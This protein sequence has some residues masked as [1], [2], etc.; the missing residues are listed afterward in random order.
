MQNSAPDFAVNDSCAGERLSVSLE[1]WILTLGN[2]T[3]TRASATGLSQSPNA[4]LASA[5]AAS[6][7][8]AAPALEE[9]GAP[10]REYVKMLPIRPGATPLKFAPDYESWLIE[11]MRHGENDSF[12]TEMGSSVVDH[13]AEHPSPI[14]IPIVPANAANQ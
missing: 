2:A 14:L 11:A 9:L 12:W 7:P 4:R 13:I 3:G 1:Y 8:A 6:N 10:V 5:R